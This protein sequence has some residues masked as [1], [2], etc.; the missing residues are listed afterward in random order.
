MFF[1]KMYQKKLKLAGCLGE[2]N[3]FIMEKYK[4]AL[5]K[6]QVDIEILC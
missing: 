1:A 4:E 2:N 6:N 5:E 3:E